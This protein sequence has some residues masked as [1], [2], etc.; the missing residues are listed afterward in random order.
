MVDCPM[1]DYQ[2]RDY[3]IR[4][5]TVGRYPTLGSLYPCFRA[6]VAMRLYLLLPK[7]F[8]LQRASIVTYL[9]KTGVTCNECDQV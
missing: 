1:V 7:R 3:P 5:H 8:E 6:C 2:M 9:P 4:D